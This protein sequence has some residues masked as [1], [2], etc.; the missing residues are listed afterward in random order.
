M[1]HKEN[2]MT[3][4]LKQSLTKTAAKVNL[5]ELIEKQL[6]NSGKAP[7]ETAE[8]QLEKARSGE[9][10]DL[11]EKQLDKARNS[12]SATDELIEAQLDGKG[13]VPTA[14]AEAQLDAGRTTHSE[15]PIEKRLDQ[16]REAGFNL[17]AYLTQKTAKKNKKDVST[18]EG[19]LGN[20]NDGPKDVTEKQL[21]DGRNESK[22]ATTEKL[23][24]KARTG[25]AT[26]LTE[27]QLDGSKSK[28]VQHRNAETSAG[29]INKL[30]E[31]RI[32]AKNTPEK[33][34][35]EAASETDKKLMLPEVK[36]KDG[37]KTASVKD[38][39]KKVLAGD[40]KAGIRLLAM[41]KVN[42]SSVQC[43][44]TFERDALANMR[45]K[46]AQA[47]SNEAESYDEYIK[48]R[49]AND[50]SLCGGAGYEMDPQDGERTKCPS[51]NGTG[52]NKQ[53][54][55]AST[56]KKAQ[57]DSNEAESYEEYIKDRLANDCSL[58]G[59]AGYEMDP[60]DGERTKCPSCN[61]T[62][63]NKQSKSASTTREAQSSPTREQVM[64]RMLR[65]INNIPGR[66]ELEFMMKK[67]PLMA[68][69]FKQFSA[70]MREATAVI[71][72]ML[73]RLQPDG[74]LKPT[75]QGETVAAEA[76]VGVTKVAGRP[77]LGEYSLGNFDVDF[78]DPFKMDDSIGWRRR[79]VTPRDMDEIVNKQNVESKSGMEE[80]AIANAASRGV[81]VPSD[82]E[83]AAAG[84][85]LVDDEE[86]EAPEAFDIDDIA[87][88]AVGASTMRQITMDFNA[89]EFES[90]REIKL[91]AAKF[92]ISKFPELIKFKTNKT[93]ADIARSIVIM[94]KDNKA[95]AT[96][97]MAAFQ[98]TEN[99]AAPVA[100]EPSPVMA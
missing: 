40:Q 45:I 97:P 6:S 26:T 20:K 58:C 63:K 37:L 12:K 32:A 7:A 92:L 36:G 15:A 79:E 96:L 16:V 70:A 33:E 18:T 83:V 10:K 11:A 22:V 64:Q 3:F 60:Q 87:D 55:S 19:Q 29:N 98:T 69:D 27:G 28:L 35:Y 89:D 78:N 90:A 39:A 30:E 66:I 65:E 1:P 46:T 76:K 34:K 91:E 100:N 24:E 51:C 9:P 99:A 52:K 61:G 72:S 71:N 81:Q 94:G 47:D 85:G 53:N 2:A 95:V 48:D 74:K 44:T 23:L 25:A 5:N 73:A 43:L 77:G 17:Q 14:T 4:N 31:Q 80:E 93:P 57:T 84:E 8:A 41:L 49:L 56:A 75:G 59:G 38:E 88:V 42:P 86:M 54:K 82:D 13:K 62:G 21:E 68:E 67:V 50:C